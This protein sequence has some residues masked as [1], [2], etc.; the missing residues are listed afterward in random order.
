MPTSA[1]KVIV[2]GPLPGGERWSVGCHFADGNG[3]ATVNLFEELDD[4]ARAIAL[5]N[6][7]NVLPLNVRALLSSSVAIEYVRTERIGADGRLA[8][9]AEYVLPNLVPGTG[10]LRNPLQVSLVASL[11]TGRP[12]RSFRGRMYWPML[13]TSLE[14]SSGRVPTA[15]CGLVAT[16]TAN[17]LRAVADTIV[18][19]NPPLDPVV[20]SQTQG[21]N[22]RVETV[23]VGDVPDTQR[24]RRDSLSEGRSVAVVPA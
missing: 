21:V 22:T 6:S 12:G 1:N 18:D 16:D 23:G 11:S 4:W 19:P 24:R 20:T 17:W 13:A 15:V 9:A 2:G 5:L 8:L 14:A 3:A 7:G 10:T